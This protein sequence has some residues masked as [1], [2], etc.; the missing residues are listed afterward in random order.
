MTLAVVHGALYGGME[1]YRR[2]PQAKFKD[3]QKLR[4]AVHKSDIEAVR[5]MLEHGAPADGDTSIGHTLLMDAKEREMAQLLI[6][7]GANLEATDQYGNTALMYAAKADNVEVVKALI[8]AGANVNAENPKFS[9][10]ALV[11]AQESRSRR[12]IEELL[13][14]G[15]HDDVATETNGEEIDETHP[16]FL[17]V[18]DYIAAI[19]ASDA[20]TMERLFPRLKGREFKAENFADWQGVRPLEPTIDTAYVRGDDATLAITGRTPKG[21]D[22]RWITQLKQRSGQW[23]IVREHWDVR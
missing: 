5:T 23:V 9:G 18:R 22:V 12:A 21:F 16:A 4:D 11:D 8:A 7:H 2:A 3:S 19:H 6:D 10:T 1:L 15:A 17:V 14:A 13:K 20:K